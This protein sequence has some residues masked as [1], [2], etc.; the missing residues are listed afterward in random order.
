VN[1]RLCVVLCVAAAQVA[2]G[3]FDSSD[4]RDTDPVQGGQDGSG[5]GEPGG[6]DP[7]TVGSDAARAGREAGS[8]PPRPTEGGAPPASL[9]A[10][11]DW[12]SDGA[13][14]SMYDASG[15][16]RDGG[17]I[18]FDPDAGGPVLN[19]EAQ[20]ACI[21]LLNNICN[22]N[23]DCQVSLLGLGASQ[24]PGLFESCRNSLW[25]ARNCNRATRTAS[26][27]AQCSESTKDLGC[28]SVVSTDLST[29]CADQITLQP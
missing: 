26:G 12:A 21:G 19:A 14:P 11:F 1:L 25:R 3:L 7:H 6:A 8:D 13:V 4:G 5:G 2:C 29:T 9:D 22:R 16:I 24:R 17:L 28:T 15:S 23:A 10:G 18:K 27:F 20:A